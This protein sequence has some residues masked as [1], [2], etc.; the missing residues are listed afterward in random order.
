MPTCPSRSIGAYATHDAASGSTPPSFRK[1]TLELPE[2]HPRTVRPTERS[3]Q[4]Q[5]TDA[6]SR[7]TR[8][9]AGRLRHVKPARV[10]LRH[11]APSP[12]QLP[13]LLYRL[14]KEQSRRSPD[15]L[16]G[17]AIKTGSESVE[18]TLRRRWILFARFVARMEDRRLPK[19]VM[20]GELVGGTGFVGDQEKE[21]M[22]CFL[23]DLKVF[24]INAYQWT[25]TAQDEGEWRKGAE[26]FMAKR[27][28]AGKAGGLRHAVVCPNVTGK[29]KE[30]IAHGELDRCRESQGCTT[31]RGIDSINS[32]PERN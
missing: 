7:G 17:H 29:T 28:A 22:G 5:N 12:P 8:D 6:L 27:I 2:V 4:T 19:C 23:G 14:A 20:F 13:D 18:V 21:W 11:A 1:Y 24:G 30:R 31:A 32:M 16:S 26:S 15:F 9:N 10:P 25:T 3:P